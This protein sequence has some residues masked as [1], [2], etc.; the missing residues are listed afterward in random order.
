MQRRDW[1]RFL[2]VALVVG[3]CLTIVGCGGGGGF[4][5]KLTKANVDKITKGMT[6][7]EVTD[8]LGPPDQKTD[9]NAEM[10]GKPGKAPGGEI[11]TSKGTI[12]FSWR[13]GEKSVAVTFVDGKVEKIAHGGF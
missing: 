2:T 9:I 10:T 11:N 13:Q 6:E 12:A 7:K 1:Q 8:I 4:G 3:L 5:S